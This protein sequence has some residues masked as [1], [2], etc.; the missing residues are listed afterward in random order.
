ML[1]HLIYKGAV[2]EV[3]PPMLRMMMLTQSDKLIKSAT[4]CIYKQH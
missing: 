3:R 4:H 2:K 1:P